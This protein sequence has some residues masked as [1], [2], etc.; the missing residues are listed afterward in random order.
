MPCLN[1][2]STAGPALLTVQLSALWTTHERCASTL[3]LYLPVKTLHQL[4]SCPQAL[5]FD[6]R[7]VHCKQVEKAK[8]RVE[9]ISVCVVRHIED[10][11]C[12]KLQYLL[13]KR[14]ESG[15]LAGWY[16]LM[17]ICIQLLVCK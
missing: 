11:R 14:P 7:L 4:L 15:L 5:S 1:K 12:A 13:V 17:P 9:H 2:R 8:R 10:A 3:L 6:I 16:A